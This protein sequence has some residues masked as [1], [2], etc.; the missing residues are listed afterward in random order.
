MTAEA[1]RFG[2]VVVKENLHDNTVTVLTLP[3]SLGTAQAKQRR[4][5]EQAEKECAPNV[6]MVAVKYY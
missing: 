6:Y 3:A 2:Y 5:S 4:Y 1:R